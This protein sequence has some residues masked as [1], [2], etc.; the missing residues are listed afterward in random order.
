MEN[1]RIKVQSP[2]IL[3]AKMSPTWG[4]EV[5]PSLQCKKVSDM[6]RSSTAPV[7]LRDA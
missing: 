2:D 4:K 3:D 5:Y 1:C 7:L 6:A